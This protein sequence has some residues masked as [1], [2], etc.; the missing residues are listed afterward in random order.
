MFIQDDIWNHIKTFLIVSDGQRICGVDFKRDKM[1][2]I[3]C[4][5]KDRKI[6]QILGLGIADV[7]IDH[8]SFHFADRI[9][10][11][12]HPWTPP[13]RRT[14][15]KRF[16]ELWDRRTKLHQINVHCIYNTF[17]NPIL[18]TYCERRR[19]RVKRFGHELLYHLNNKH[20][21]YHLIDTLCMIKFWIND[22]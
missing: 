1:S 2:V 22:V 9:L 21:A 11:K 18:G 6:K 3:S 17:D 5:V 8:H 7:T 19:N 16:V 20:D 10:C 12:Y 14:S 13:V 4:V 15:T